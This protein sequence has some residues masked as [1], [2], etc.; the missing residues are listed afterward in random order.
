MELVIDLTLDI[1]L[2]S[3]SS[4][5]LGC[6]NPRAVSMKV[7][8]CFG[9]TR[10]IVPCGNGD[11]PVNE[12]VSKVGWLVALALCSMIFA[13]FS[14]ALLHAVIPRVLKVCFQFG[15]CRIDLACP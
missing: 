12:L 2:S 8:V 14:A 3:S 4:S 7:T 6:S 5:V 13:S 11:I 1:P 9:N 15:D 10:V